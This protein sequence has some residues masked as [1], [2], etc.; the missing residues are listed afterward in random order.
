MEV[1]RFSDP[2][3]ASKLRGKLITKPVEFQTA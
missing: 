1:S 2:V 3:Y